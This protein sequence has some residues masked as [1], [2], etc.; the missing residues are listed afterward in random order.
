M[1]GPEIK[2]RTLGVWDRFYS[3]KFIWERSAVAGSAWSRLTFIL[4]SKLYR[5]M[6]AGTGIS[7]DSARANRAEMWARLIARPCRWLFRSRPMEHLQVPS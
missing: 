5:Q 2:A 6:Y 1:S 7:S 3:M 4:M